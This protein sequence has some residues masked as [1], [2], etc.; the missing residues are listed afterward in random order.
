MF[1]K[2]NKPKNMTRRTALERG[3]GVAALGAASAF[4]GAVSNAPAASAAA[5]APRGNGS[6]A[7]TEALPREVG[8]IRIPRSEVAQKAAAFAR[9]ES[10]VTLF[11]HVMRTYL[12]GCVL[13]DQRGVHYDREI[14][15]VASILHDLG[16][17]EKYRSPNERFELDGADVAQQFLRKQRMSADR[18]EVVWDAIALHTNRPIALRKRPEIAM[19]SVGSGLDFAG[20]ELEKIPSEILDDILDAFPREG[21]KKNAVDT[22]LSLCR[23]KPMSVLMHPFAE[24]GRR[25]LPDFAV[26]TVEDVLLAA[27]FAE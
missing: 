19:V 23:T 5:H 9:S 15:F 11:N 22:M 7:G 1:D 4:A 14:A 3:V 2:G 12:F 25:H 26:P 21:F 6:T 18:V 24:V 17:V 16:M 10:S 27:P 8:G 20:N 13:F